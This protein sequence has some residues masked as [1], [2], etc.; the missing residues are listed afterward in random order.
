MLELPRPPS[1]WAFVGRKAELELALAELDAGRSGLVIAGPPGVGRT[2]FAHEIARA[3]T[4]RGL[5]TAWLPG[6]AAEP[7]RLA[8]CE[9][10][11][12]GLLVVDDAHLLAAP[13]ARRLE[14]VVRDG[15]VFLV[16]TLLSGE[17]GP[18]AIRALWK[19]AIAP[20]IDLPPLGEPALA[21]LLESALAARVER[22]TCRLL[23]RAC[24]GNLVWLRELLREGLARG[25]L[26]R[27]AA[28][29]RY[30]GPL[31][32]GAP[33]AELA[34]DPVQSL[35]EAAYRAFESIAIAERLEL[36][37]LD[38]ALADGSLELLERRGLI[39]IE[40]DGLRS[41]ARVAQPLCGAAVRQAMPRTRA[42]QIHREL[43]IALL[44]LG[45]RRS[46]D[47]FRVAT[48]LLEGDPASGAPFFASAGEEAWARGNAALAERF[49]RA[50]LHG[51]HA[52]YARHILAE[53]LAD[54]NRFEEALAEWEALD[55]TE[56]D[57]PLRARAA[58]SRGAIL[59]FARGR[60][61]EAREILER[62]EQR[63]ASEELKRP[64]AALRASIGV[65][66]RPPERIVAETEEVLREPDLPPYVEWHALASQSR[67]AGALGRFERV[68]EERPRAL[69][70]SRRMKATNPFG[71]LYVHVNSFYALLFT[72]ALD[73][74]EQL[75]T[76]RREAHAEDPFGAT[77]GYW[78][79]GV[80]LV[81]LWRG[82][83]GEATAL[84]REAAA[85]LLTYDNGARQAVL[86]D[87]AM[88]RALAG[89]GAEAEQ[90][91]REGEAARPA[92][93]VMLSERDRA[94]AFVRAAGGERSAARELLVEAGRGQLASGR[95]APAILALHDAIRFGAGVET[96]QVLR[97]AASQTDGPLLPAL[98]DH[99]LALAR[100]DAPAL[101]DISERLAALGV[102]FYAADAARAACEHH[103]KTGDAAAALASRN[104]F[105]RLAA[106]CEGAAFPPLGIG[107]PLTRREREVAELAARGAS[108][109]EIAARL[110]LSVRTVNA[111]LRAVYGKL[112][113]EGRGALRALLAPPG[114]PN[115]EE[116]GAK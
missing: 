112:E 113:V 75:A 57:D 101:D 20:R 34:L 30:S 107:D 11:R 65:A 92:P 19:E 70:A 97:R 87:L 116:D 114:E 39:A 110:S 50:A 59:A 2:R 61:Q 35:P 105:E 79:Y 47:R 36:A 69:R 27:H 96:A 77:R 49:A 29:W 24:S 111:H 93:P 73:A 100:R 44:G 51:E 31:V 21:E 82:R 58:R 38:A 71:E 14:R 94:R 104:T 41:T 108:D 48:L 89:A 88:A 53:A 17:R 33:L 3:A 98:A 23:F 1:D 4:A 43:G 76:E 5:A 102:L 37:L 85:L 52:G 45:L 13:A 74:A 81:L 106:Q 55:A 86:F 68:L 67:A 109:R 6:D 78:T 83:V 12:P 63:V 60:A 40:R 80:G 10:S 28:V 8:A 9:A 25:V 22:G 32:L 99:G 72:A 95:P 7:E 26:E 15:G 115:R 16:A 103:A 66:D 56:I 54:Q 90:I 91:L 46:G 18:A 64:L 84:L 42:L 62:A